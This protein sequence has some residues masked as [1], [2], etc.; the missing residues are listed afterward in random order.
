MKELFKSGKLSERQSIESII[1]KKKEI[2]Y[3]HE[4]T[5]KPYKG[6]SVFEIDLDTLLVSPAEY[7]ERK[8]IQWHE[9]I[10]FMESGYKQDISVKKNCVY[11]SA[12]NAKSALERFKKDKGSATLPEG[13]LE[14]KFY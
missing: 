8:N 7:V 12:L 1:K 5:I 6:H 4:A 11:I 13:R 2:E 10:K 3:K 14:L 9:A